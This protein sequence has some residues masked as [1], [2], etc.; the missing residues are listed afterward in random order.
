MHQSA[1]ENLKINC[2]ICDVDGVL[3]DGKFST[4]PDGTE[5]KFF[6]AHDGLGL[7]QLM[8]EGINVIWISGRKADCVAQRA[9]KLGIEHCYQGIDDKLPLFNKLCA[10]LNFSPQETAYIGDDTPDVA[11]MQVVALPIAVAQATAA[12]KKIAKLTTARRGGDGAVREAC[13]WILEHRQN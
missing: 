4:L 7:K 5:I 6:H 12:A 2:L 13:E 8:K 9:A 11:I 10:E 1:L 3:T